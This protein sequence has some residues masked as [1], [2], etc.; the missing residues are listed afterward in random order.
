MGIVG[1]SP[2]NTGT[3]RGEMILRQILL[4][5]SAYVV[6]EPQMH[7]PNS[8]ERF[9]ENG[10]TAQQTRA[11]MHRFLTALAERTERTGAPVRSHGID[12]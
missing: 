9:D 3:A 8:R 4:Y 7:I 12:A 5:A 11:R 1:E 10:D 2:A 6:R